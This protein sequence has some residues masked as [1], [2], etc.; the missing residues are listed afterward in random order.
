[1]S[2]A[3]SSVSG[4]TTVRAANPVPPPG[5]PPAANSGASMPPPGI[6]GSSGSV[7]QAPPAGDVPGNGGGG[8]I[9]YLAPPPA[10]HPYATVFMKSHVPV[11]LTMKS[12]AYSR[13]ASFFK[14]MG[15]AFARLRASDVSG[16]S[17][18]MH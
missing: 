10:V 1:M 13:W 15:F 4:D 16:L 11:M 14:S 9:V 8:F 2:S 5:P 3:D 7:P 18:L 6:G 12:H 17:Y